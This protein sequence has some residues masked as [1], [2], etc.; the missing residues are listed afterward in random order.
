[1]NRPVRS[2][3]APAAGPI[4][5]AALSFVIVLGIGL[6]ANSGEPT[7]T[8]GI[9][10]PVSSV[11]R[12]RTSRPDDG[13]RSTVPGKPTTSATDRSAD[14]TPSKAGPDAEESDT[15]ECHRPTPLCPARS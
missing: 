6:V 13:D 7:P 5:S 4:L 11:Q 1:M 9:D 8:A 14:E 12:S 10:Q 2:T 15:D 3:G